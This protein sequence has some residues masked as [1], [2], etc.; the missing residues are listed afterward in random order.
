MKCSTDGAYGGKAVGCQVSRE[1]HR[2]AL[3]ERIGRVAILTDAGQ[4][5]WH[6]LAADDHHQ[7]LVRCGCANGSVVTGARLD[8]RDLAQI[9]GGHVGAG[10]P[11][12]LRAV[13]LRRHEGT[14]RT[15]RSSYSPAARRPAGPGPPLR[16]R[17]PAQARS[18]EHSLAS[19]AFSP[20]TL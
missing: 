6:L 19:P 20:A 11:K 17:S 7:E 5:R 18:Q 10:L 15:P 2:S 1:H 12:V 16:R 4:N 8:V 9:P 13:V 14:H 3:A